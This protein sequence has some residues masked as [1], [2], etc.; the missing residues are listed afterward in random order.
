[1]ENVAIYLSEFPCFLPQIANSQGAVHGSDLELIPLKISHPKRFK[2]ER[3][4]QSINQSESEIPTGGAPKWQLSKKYKKKKEKK[5][6]KILANQNLHECCKNVVSDWGG[7][8][9]E[10]GW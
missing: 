4:A 9:L 8:F 1:M 3:H 7:P 2:I 5:T 10:V 6:N